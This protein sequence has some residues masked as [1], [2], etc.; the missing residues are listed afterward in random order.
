M[1]TIELDGTTLEGGGQ[2]LRLALTLSSLTGK[3]VHVAHVRG[4]RGALSAAGIGK[5]GGLK[6][7][8]LAAAKWLAQATA[9]TT[10]GMEVRSTDLL[11]LPTRGIAEDEVCDGQGVWKDV[12]ENGLLIRRETEIPMST[13]GSILLV[14]QAILP[15]ILYLPSP[16][17]LRITIHGGTNV[18]KSP[19]ID[20]VSQVLL[21]LLST[22]LNI[23]PIRVFL[24][25]RG[26]SVGQGEVGCVTFE[27]TPIPRGSMQ[28]AIVFTNRG[29]VEK[30]HV[31]MVADDGT[32]EQIKSEA[33]KQLGEALPGVELLWAVDEDSGNSQ[34]VYIL[35]VAE[36]SSGFR[37]GR[38]C[39]F[40]RK[41][42]K[43]RQSQKEH[44]AGQEHIRLV[45]NVVREL[46]KELSWE[47]C[48]DEY[49]EDQ[50]VVFEALAQGRSEVNAG[51]GRQASLHTQTARWVA[52]RILGV[53]FK[54]GRCDGSGF[55][56]GD[57]AEVLGG[58][59]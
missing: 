5:D 13:A 23:Q 59:G 42:P 22:K 36:T 35:L 51:R 57:G 8:H 3:P 29:K 31:S 9:A 21:P 17:P 26:W 48:V 55:K 50:L 32:R 38:D 12:R 7:A 18:S 40:S 14:L 6:P 1:A 15:Y 37:L 47:G 4:K 58:I 49:M 2:L 19:S 39:L 20:Y 16:V 11:F 41:S 24:H 25:K 43:K 28:P 54:E 44:R 53:A 45:S 30:V 46:Q 34:Q 52:E 27:I 33:H 56:S 10:Q